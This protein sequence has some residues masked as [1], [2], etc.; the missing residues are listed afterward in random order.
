MYWIQALVIIDETYI[1]V[2]MLS[3]LKPEHLWGL[4]FT[5]DLKL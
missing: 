2:S 4:F 1:T 5:T 3:C